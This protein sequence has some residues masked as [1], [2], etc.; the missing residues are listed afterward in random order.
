[1]SLFIVVGSRNATGLEEV[2][3]ADFGPYGLLHAIK[4]TVGH[5]LESDQWGS[6][7]PLLMNRSDTDAHYTAEEASKLLNEIQQIEKE[8]QRHAPS[9]V[10]WAKEAK[11]AKPLTYM[12]DLDA[13][14]LADYFGIVGGEKALKVLQK[15]CRVAIEREKDIIFS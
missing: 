13:T 8:L 10:V 2:A 3:S 1:M 5:V 6:R 4:S 11:Y 15:L 9:E 14:S 12:V 7:F